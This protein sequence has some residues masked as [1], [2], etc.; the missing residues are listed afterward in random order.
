MLA[1]LNEQAALLAR[2]GKHSCGKSRLYINRLAD[3]DTAVLE[4]IVAKGLA[5]ARAS[6]GV[7]AAS[8]RKSGAKRTAA[9]KRKAKRRRR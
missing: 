5:A 7:P 6:D 2:L 1:S 3:V 9:P 8:T 4:Q